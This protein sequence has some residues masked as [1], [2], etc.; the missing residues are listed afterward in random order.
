MSS[1]KPQNISDFSIVGK[2]K[3]VVENK[4]AYFTFDKEGYAFM[5]VKG[6]KIGGKEFE[7]Q[8]KKGSMRYEID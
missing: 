6:M 4:A 8:G 7:L 3:G 2:W 1:F 5:E